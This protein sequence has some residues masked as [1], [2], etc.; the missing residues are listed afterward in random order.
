MPN[1]TCIIG[2]I[3]GRSDHLTELI[4]AV[5][6]RFGHEI[7]FIGVGDYIDRGPDSRGVIDICVREGFEGIAGNHDLWLGKYLRTGE[8]DRGALHWAMGGKAT[9]QSYT[10]E[11]GLD[12]NAVEQQLKNHVP[13]EHTAFFNRLLIWLDIEVAGI[14]YRITHGGVKTSTVERLRNSLGARA[15]ELT[16]DKLL[17]VIA[18]L[19]VDSLLWVHHSGPESV[20]RYGDGSVQVFGHKPN[21]KV[22]QTDWYIGLDTGSGRARRKPNSLSAVVLPEDGGRYIITGGRWV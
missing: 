1:A 21:D 11:A 13:E 9:I 3:H 2:D 20:Y 10:R 14:T 16:D 4:D 15:S 12:P 6:L 19:E 22:E 7:R 18:K 8:F 5:R 17:P